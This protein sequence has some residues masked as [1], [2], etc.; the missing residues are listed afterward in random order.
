MVDAVQFAVGREGGGVVDVLVHVDEA[1]DD[2]QAA[3]GRDDPLQLAQVVA[4][5]ARL[6]QQVLGRIARQGQLR[7]DHQVGAL[8]ARVAD[9][10]HDPVGVAHQVADDG[11]E[12]GQGHPEY[13]G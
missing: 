5:E 4:D 11:V 1:D 13:P 7:E 3:A 10:L 2:G 9:P 8:G 6:Q 12:L